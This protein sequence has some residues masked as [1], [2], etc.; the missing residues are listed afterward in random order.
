MTTPEDPR[1]AAR[2]LLDRGDAQAAFAALRGAIEHPVQLDDPDETSQSFAVFEEIARA[3]AGPELAEP[4][5][6]VAAKPD[7]VQALYDAAYALYEQG[8]QRISV[9]LLYRA[10]LLAPGRFEI[11]TE[12]VSCLEHVLSYGEAALVADASGL[13]DRD[14]L[15]AYLSGFNWF[16]VGD[17]ERARLRLQQL[18]GISDRPIPEVREALAGMIARADA[19]ERVSALD[20]RALVGWHLAI[21]GTILL[22]ESPHGWDEPMRGRYAYVSDSPGLM[23]EGLER[24]RSVLGDR[25]PSRVVAAPDRASTILGLAAASLFQRPMLPFD[26][27]ALSDALVV[28]WTFESVTDPTF[29]RA[30][31][32]HA[33]G[34]VLFVHGSSWVDPLGY[35]PDVTTFL[36]QSVTHPYLG[37][38]LRVDPQTHRVAPAEPDT[39]SDE[40]LAQEILSAERDDCDKP[41]I[42]S[43]LALRD[44]VRDIPDAWAAGLHRS[45]GVRTRER[46][47]SA[48]PSARFL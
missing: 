33:P 40:E 42:E 47:G 9:A 43:I 46:A 3:L 45:S 26:T 1:S 7:D 12:L 35:A 10:N 4:I 8:L 44:A 28:V 17:R 29:L 6:R 27:S 24:L 2:A 15:C 36:Y 16:M 11:V 13:A 18:T 5:G 31:Q 22:H 19:I 25:V 23:R 14:P 20:D 37:G 38:A 32:R 39:R 41:A 34:Q 30:L 21:N 48:V